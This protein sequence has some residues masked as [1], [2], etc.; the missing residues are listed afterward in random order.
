MPAQ[1][2]TKLPISVI[3]GRKTVSRGVWSVPSWRAVAVVSGDNLASADASGTLIREADDEQHFLWGGLELPL[4]RDSAHS[5]WSNLVGN[6]PALF[7]I[8]HEGEEGDQVPVQVTADQDEASATIEA[9]DAVYPVPIP[10]EVYV[11]LERFV[12]EHYKPTP[13]RKRKRK[14]WSP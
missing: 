11:R 10:P 9:G 2:Q 14:N 1:P 4:F 12:V 7:V 8:C 5:Y 3:L 13:P 6:E